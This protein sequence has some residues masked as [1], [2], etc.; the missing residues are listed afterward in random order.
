MGR[1]LVQSA[2]AEVAGGAQALDMYKV[3]TSASRR[4]DPQRPPCR[5]RRPCEVGLT[6]HGAFW[7][8]CGRLRLG[9][10]VEARGEM[11]ASRGAGQSWRATIRRQTLPGASQRGRPIG[12]PVVPYPSPPT[13]LMP[14]QRLRNF[15]PK[16]YAFPVWSRDGAASS[17]AE[18]RNLARGL[19][20]W[21][22]HRSDARF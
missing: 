19:H 10:R 5:R 13:V 3:A 11:R 4:A 7:F 17:R 16:P 20:I 22:Q 21:S 12:S 1:L 15:Y 9:G 2:L 6:R 8:S 18:V 14:F